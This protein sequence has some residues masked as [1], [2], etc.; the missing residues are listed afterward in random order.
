MIQGRDR[1]HLAGEE[2]DGL[3][4]GHALKRH[5]LNGNAPAQ[6]RQLLSLVHIAKRAR[7]NPARY[8]AITKRRA[9]QQKFTVAT[10]NLL[11]DRNGRGG[12]VCA[13]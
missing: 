7:T 12:I 3:L 11:F 2:F 1:A 10:R 4:I 8:A 5:D 6:G 13:R 9:P